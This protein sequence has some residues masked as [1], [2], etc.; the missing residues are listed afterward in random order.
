MTDPV[1][2]IVDLKAPFSASRNFSI[3]AIASTLNVDAAAAWGA[4]RCRR[5][6]KDTWKAFTTTYK[7]AST[8]PLY[9]AIAT[10]YAD[11]RNIKRVPEWC[12]L[13]R[14]DTPVAQ[15]W[16]FTVGGAADGTYRLFSDG[17]EVAVVNAVGLTDVQIRD[18]LVTAYNTTNPPQ[19]AANAADPTGTV[20]ADEAGVS[21]A[22]TAE[23]PN[24]ALTVAVTTANVGI[25]ED[26]TAAIG[27]TGDDS[28]YAWTEASLSDGVNLNAAKFTQTASR[29]LLFFPQSNS[30]DITQNVATDAF[31]KMKTLGYGRSSPWYHPRDSEFLAA[32]V[33]GRCLAQPVGQINWA[34]RQIAT[35]AP[36]PYVLQAGVAD[37]LE[38]KNVNRYDA[39]E[40]GSTLY[41]TM[42][43]GLFIDQAILRDVLE[44][45][46]RSVIIQLLQSEDFVAYDETPEG[47][48]L[49]ASTILGYA[50]E[51]ERQGALMRGASSVSTGKLAD[52]PSADKKVRNWPAFKL[53]TKARGPMNR[54][55][56]LTVTVLL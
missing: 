46:L 3:P 55:R 42:S 1:N 35:V 11:H 9:G 26:M 37:I 47:A 18:Q 48:Q 34:H 51:L 5:V 33:L 6:S 24:D 17:V 43:D 2:I 16:T 23:S 32:G 41:G 4:T 49:V 19:T 52:I 29:R 28:F 56:D 8:D 54:V 13:I 15:V 12:V 25:E 30:A 38:G 7:I 53:H 40:L 39:I 10:L 50:G 44:S 27:A 20:T 14:R 22:L 45:G 31:S 36:E 21:F